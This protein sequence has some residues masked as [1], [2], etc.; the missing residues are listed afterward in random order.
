MLESS[1]T[2]SAPKAKKEV[3]LTEEVRASLQTVVNALADAADVVHTAHWNLRSN[4]FTAIHP[5]FGETYD[6]LRDMMDG[7]AEQIKIS[8]ID[9]MVT[10]SRN[11][12]ISATDEQELFGMVLVALQQVLATLAAAAADDSLPRDLQSTIDVW[13]ADVKKMVWFVKASMK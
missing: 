1:Q 7:A 3:L 5:W 13:T 2:V 9:L 12:T 8:D 11:M 6:A 10:I 4:A